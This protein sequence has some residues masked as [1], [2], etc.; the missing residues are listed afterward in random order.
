MLKPV[1]TRGLMLDFIRDEIIC[2][3]EINSNRVV[4]L[5]DKPVQKDGDIVYL[6]SRELRVED[7]WAMVFASELAKKDN[8]KL[9][10]VII[11]EDKS[12]SKKQEP[13]LK[14]GLNFLKKNLALNNIEFEVSDQ[15]PENIGALVTDFNPL[16]KNSYA[17]INC[18]VFE[19]DSHN[20]IPARFISNK[21]EFSAAT[22]RRKVYANITDCLTEFPTAFKLTKGKAYEKLEDFIKNKLDF[23]SEYKNDPNKDV[24][25]NLSPYLHFGFISAQ[26]IALEV[27]KSGALRE[28][29]ETFL[30]ELV[31]RKE[32][33]DNFCL[34][35]NNYKSLEGI[36]SWAKESLNTHREDL[37]TYVYGLKEFE[38]AKTHDEFWNAIQLN[39]LK[40]GEIHGYLRM[41]WAKKIL[42]WS[43]TPQDALDIAIYLNDKY[44][45]DGNAPNGYVGILWSIGGLHDRAFANR[46]VTG[47]IRYMSLQGCNKKFDI[48]NYIE[49]IRNYNLL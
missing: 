25:S 42:E 37:R 35:N 8:K 38:Y 18:A 41:Y 10:V 21:Q 31:V 30:E 46:L 14:E 3:A 26:R 33:A 48:N 28:N 47:K 49:K 27:L 32:L 13:F 12:Y 19:V 16:N 15:I 44:A 9:K 17:K 40:L 5:N 6:M 43:N 2:P 4:K 34:Y 23:Y 7:N 22:L 36:S 20:I 29:K 11:L 45:L 24:T 1:V 39:L